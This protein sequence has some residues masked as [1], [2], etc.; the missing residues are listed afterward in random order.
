VW[1]SLQAERASAVTKTVVNESTPAPL[2][3]SPEQIPMLAAPIAA[4]APTV[5]RAE[6]LSLEF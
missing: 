3:A 5:V 2:I 6:Q 1:K 4:T